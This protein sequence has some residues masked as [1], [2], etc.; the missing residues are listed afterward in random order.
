MHHALPRF[1]L[2]TAL[3]AVLTACL[4]LPGL[5]GGFVFDDK[6]NIVDNAALHITALDVTQLQHASFSFEP[7]QGSRP[8]A[9]FSFAL[10]YLRAGLNPQA[11]KTT[12]LL[13]H[14]LTTLV[15]A[16]FLRLLFTL[17][18]WPPRRA[19]IGALII[20][21][22]WA[23]HPLQVSSV[24]YVVQRMQTLVTLFTILALWAYLRMRQAQMEGQRSRQFGIQ[25]LLFWALGL[26]SKED[27]ILL[28]AFTLALELTVLRFGTARA[29]PNTTLRRSYA[30]LALAGL[31]V[32]FL[33][34]LPHYWHWG[35]YPTRE[36][37]SS[38]RLFTQGRVLALY[39]QQILLPLPSSMPFFYDDYPIS[40]GWLQPPTTLA[41]WLLIA[42]LLAWAWLWRTRRPLF[43]LGIFLF[44]AG[45]VIT[46]NVIG[47][48]LVFEH[49]NHFPMLGILLATADLCSMAYQRWPARP[50]LAISLA[51]IA[52]L[53]T[54]CA[55][56][57][58][59]YVWGNPLRFAQNSVV[60][61]P[62][63][64][65][66]WMTLGGI[67]YERSGGKAGNPWL[68]KAIEIN[69]QG[70]R[71]TASAPMLSN[72]VI[73]KTIRGDVTPSD[74]TQFLD[75]LQQ[76]PMNAQNKGI[77][78]TTLDN[79]DRGISLDEK[80]VIEALEIVNQRTILSPEE[81]LR[82]AAYL[83]NETQQPGKALPY[84]R[85]AVEHSPP[86][87]PAI[88]QMLVQL[89]EAGRE[90]WLNELKRTEQRNSDTTPR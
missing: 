90:D 20:T 39:L 12:N 21:T 50:P 76:V 83:H 81:Y 5:S 75:R 89:K 1:S 78:F 88:A 70:A 30:A 85:S 72:I 52:L 87:S 7:G 38:E 26:A 58:R 73:F 25:M 45:H 82:I 8:L 60:A 17:A 54:G 33:V 11:F 27:A 64:P 19:T 43:S 16:H 53:A 13:I 59:T 84:L 9:M 36:F 6:P 3:V 2:L 48:E 69:Q 62:H 34:I 51:T 44:F 4:F 40:R 49:R 18:Q 80:G 47:L 10:D 65:R 71:E 63:S 79:V 55:T 23:I 57:W 32:F 35:N 86:G 56:I 66:A 22:L 46:S 15:L 42:T 77:A 68:D 74:W 41:S 37:S 61:S 67:Y 29:T 14:A 31:A 24:L 28:P